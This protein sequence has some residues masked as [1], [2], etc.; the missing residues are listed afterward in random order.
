MHTD[1]PAE[2]VEEARQVAMESARRVIKRCPTVPADDLEGEALT[3]AYLRLLK[4]DP[5]KGSVRSWCRW[6]VT[7]ALRHYTH[8][9]VKGAKHISKDDRSLR[10]EHMSVLEWRRVPLP[11]SLQ[12]MGDD[13]W[14]VLLRPLSEYDRRLL[15][16]M[17]REGKGPSELVPEFGPNAAAVGMRGTTARKR[18]TLL[19]GEKSSA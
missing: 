8:W 13:E 14:E 17:H 9:W 19:W 6:A 3:G 7:W 1:L 11:E 5:E 12:V 4:Y 18:L 16:A 15:L 10:A 2:W